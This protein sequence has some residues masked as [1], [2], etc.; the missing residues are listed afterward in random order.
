[1]YN[2]LWNWIRCSEMELSIN[3]AW[4][5]TFF[6]VLALSHQ[7]S[8]CF[9]FFLLSCVSSKMTLQT[10]QFCLVKTFCQIFYCNKDITFFY[11]FRKFLEPCLIDIVVVKLLDLGHSHLFSYRLSIL[12]SF[13]LVFFLRHKVFLRM[14]NTYL[15]KREKNTIWWM[16]QCTI[17]TPAIYPPHIKM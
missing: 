10:N 13:R 9:F 8:C 15:V 5:K 11:S 17:G 14:R 6:S 16:V 12:I 2:L 3:Y 7:C 4:F 1:M